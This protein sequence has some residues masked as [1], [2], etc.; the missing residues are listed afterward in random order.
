MKHKITNRFISVALAV[1]MIVSMVPSSAFADVTSEIAVTP[2]SEAQI[3]EV[4]EDVAQS[5]ESNVQEEA[6][7]SSEAPVV[8]PSEE[9]APAASE[10]PAETVA[11]SAVPSEQPQPSAAPSEQ[12]EESATPSEQPEQSAQPESSALPESSASPE[13]TATPIPSETPTPSESPLPSEE[14]EASE[15][16]V[17]MNEEEYT[18]TANVEGAEGVTVVVKVPAN[19]LPKDV[20]LVAELLEQGTEAHEEAQEALNNAQVAYESMVAMDIRFEDKD[21]NEVEPL[22]PV[23]VSIDAQALLPVD[24]DP[25]TVA[26]QH[27]KENEAGEVVAV[28]TVADA[29]VTT[30]EITV[31]ENADQ[32]TQNVASTFAVDGFSY[33][34]ITWGRYGSVQVYYVDQDGNE[35]QGSQIRDEWFDTKDWVELEDYADELEGYEFVEY[36]YG[37]DFDSSNYMADSNDSPEIRYKDGGYYY[38]T[39]GHGDGT[40]IFRDTYWRN[41]YLV[42]ESEEQS[43]GSTQ[44]GANATITTQKSLTLQNGQQAG[45]LYDLTLGISG[46]RGSSEQKAMVDVLFIVDRSNSMADG[47]SY[48]DYTSRIEAVRS[49]VNGLVDTIES[50]KN[51]DAKYSTVAFSDL[52]ATGVI[53]DWTFN[54]QDI[55]DTLKYMWITGGT[56]YQAGI[57][58]GKQQL[59]QARKGA[60]TIVIFLSDGIPTFHGIYSQSGNGKNDNEGENIDA[61]V[62]EVSGMNSTAFYAVGIGP[63]FATGETG[64]NNMVR[65][66][67]A[68]NAE[69]KG[70]YSAQDTTAL[71]NAFKSIA[72]QI[73]FY[74][75]QN[76]TLTDTMSQYAQVTTDDNGNYVFTVKVENNGT[77]KASQTVTF[78]PG[79]TSK[80]VSLEGVG[81]VTLTFDGTT[82]TLD[83]PDNYK[84]EKDH[85]Y[86]V[87]T[88]VR[89][90]DLAIEAGPT[91]FNARGDVGTGS[92]AGE[93]GFYSNVNETSKVTFQ[94]IVD[95]QVGEQ[96]EEFFPK[97][98]IQVFDAGDVEMEEP[99]HTK[100]AILQDDGTYDLTLTVSGSTGTATKKAQVDVLMVVDV[101][102]SMNDDGRLSN[103]K[104][105]MNALVNK[106]NSKNTV[107]ARY[108]IVTFNGY[109]TANIAGTEHNA[110][111]K[112][113]WSNN[114]N[115]AINTT[116][117]LSATGGTNYQAGLRLAVQQ[118]KSARSTASTVVV[119]LSDGGPTLYIGGGTGNKNLD[120]SGNGWKSTLLEAAQINCSQF[121]AVGIGET[122][123]NYMTDLRDKVTAV[124]KEYFQADATGSNLASKFEDIAGSITKLV[125]EN[126]TI[127]DTLSQYAEAVLKTDGQPEKLEVKVLDENGNDVTQAEVAAGGITANYDA[128]TNTVTMDFN[129]SYALKAEYTYSVTLK[130]KASAQ[131]EA[132][133]TGTYPDTPD[134]GTGTHADRHENGFYSN[135]SAT[136]VYTVTGT[137][138]PQTIYYDHPVIQ[139]TTGNLVITKAFEGLDAQQIQSLND[140][141]TFTYTNTADASDTDSITLGDMQLVNGKYQYTVQGL[142][143]NA[144]YMVTED[145]YDVA[146]YDRSGSDT[147]V[148]VTISANG[149][150]T[151]DFENKYTQNFNGKI[152]IEK[153][154]LSY[155]YSMGN[156]ASFQFKIEAT[157]GKY[158][159]RVWYRYVTYAKGETGVKTVDV[160]G[161]PAGTYVVTELDSAGYELEGT[162]QSYQVSIA[163]GKEEK[164]T[165]ANKATTNKVPGDQGI[166][167][168][169]FK[170]VEGKGWTF[171]QEQP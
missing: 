115:T 153:N 88:T 5:I 136:L 58:Q 13:A 74:A 86:S 112:L 31:E 7:T 71:N 157:E 85:T 75:C 108:S 21:G 110:D 144:T 42:Y 97:P 169:N 47:I 37:S 158:A 63:D 54:G 166:V 148:S 24:A 14:P 53:N 146:D 65:L 123:R 90:T 39:T 105:A 80:T 135:T 26:V 84:L 126:V 161:L 52:S 38:R 81:E 60:A 73:S 11:P 170:Y 3:N 16:P 129:D 124:T 18:A 95:N 83:F 152:T 134:K 30:G 165:F 160:T 162:Q 2:T 76:V 132:E 104:K 118:L 4:I 69:N 66:K 36:R 122:Q 117:S 96:K 49:A 151:A 51:I 15:E 22:N 79:E 9:P 141:L 33:F 43:G 164:V 131:A 103:T 12:P 99:A 109:E 50:N 127:T 19:T 140:V 40:R 82:I 101:S 32:T 113:D 23:E 143:A 44:P 93:S 147:Q 137:N 167:R 116:N 45:G 149:T 57:Y 125:C 55:K 138:Q 56:N 171:V 6:A 87:T 61:A 119:F 29:T 27:L 121:Y 17:Q 168:N 48:F 133:Y 128:A 70:V 163:A 145:H 130:I 59:N 25:E 94:P 41:I 156:D 46:D 77:T 159:G 28:E 91:E 154:L 107:D 8:E 92:H 62:K 139:V 89:P 35:I 102:D 100:Q 68:A 78:A 150:A 1:A 20:T 114:A 10:V 155:N 64:Y 72:S 142:D 67:N 34:T 120:R 106:L 111:L 98:V